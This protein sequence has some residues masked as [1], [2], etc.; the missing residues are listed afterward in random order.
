M[1]SRFQTHLHSRFPELSS[2][3]VLVAV[4][5]GVDSMVLV[6]LLREF[7]NAVAVAH[8]NFQL[9]GQDSAQD[10]QLVESYCKRHQLTCHIK[11]FDTKLP[12]QSTQMAARTLR[13]NWF[14]ELCLSNNY[15]VI[16]TAHHADDNIE[17][18]LMNI[19][20]GTGIE[21]LAGIP[22]QNGRILRP[23]LPFY[24][25]EIIAYAQAHHIPWR[26][27]RSNQSGEYQRNAIRHH[28]IPEL[29]KLNP[30]ALENTT[31]TIDFTKEAAK[32]IQQQNEQLKKQ[33]FLKEKE[34]IRISISSVKALQPFSFW[35]HQLFTPYGFDH[36]E[37][38]K[39]LSAQK[40]KCI[41]STDH[42]LEVGRNELLLYKSIEQ[43]KEMEFEVYEYGIHE[44]IELL[45]SR[46]Q[47]H[48][49]SSLTLD[50]TAISFPM[51]LRKWNRGDHFCPTGMSGSKKVSKYFKDEKYTATE[52]A[53]QWLLCSGNDI[54]WIVGKR[55]DRRFVPTETTIDFLNINLK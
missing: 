36:R 1:K 18:L 52:K 15:N 42:T 46:D 9:R 22:E 3:R 39:L 19:V 30:K 44:P 41:H 35:I 33:L 47:Q 53:A 28:V 31:K 37:V 25:S 43:K 11:R 7:S 45:F 29:V 13:Y 14:E 4:S 32:V 51:K 2:Q 16:L 17:T 10:E 20:R 40:G 8:C 23:L 12:K 27:D 6:D 48:E 38:I 34:T 55:A 54:V 5:G 26:E 49:Q 21:G 50:A 24:K